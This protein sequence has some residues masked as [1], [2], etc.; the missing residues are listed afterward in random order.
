MGGLMAMATWEM[1]LGGGEMRVEDDLVSGV[2]LFGFY[3]ELMVQPNLA[4]LYSVCHHKKSPITLILFWQTIKQLDFADFDKN[5]SAYQKKGNDESDDSYG[6]F[7]QQK[8]KELTV[9][10]GRRAQ[11]CNILLSK[12]KVTNEEISKAILT[13]DSAEIIPKDMLEQVSYA[14]YLT[15]FLYV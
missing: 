10:D 7:K 3:I 11:N 15:G 4:S 8:P 12:L 5:F 6:S 1:V 2:C 9:I 14:M 13:M